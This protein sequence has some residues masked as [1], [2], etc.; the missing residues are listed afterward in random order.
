MQNF[1][2][3]LPRPLSFRRPPH[4]FLELH[5]PL[6]TEEHLRKTLHTITL[7][8]F[9]VLDL[10]CQTDG[11]RRTRYVLDI[12]PIMSI[13][14]FCHSMI[15][16]IAVITLTFKLCQMQFGCNLPYAMLKKRIEI[17]FCEIKDISAEEKLFVKLCAF[18]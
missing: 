16:V 15:T 4:F 1:K 5:P 10:Q 13:Y 9:V 3:D 17:L 8:P 2:Q 7:H 6:T 14:L 18:S 11:P 12:C